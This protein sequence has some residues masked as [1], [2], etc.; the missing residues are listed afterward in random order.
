ML[1]Q[2]EGEMKEILSKARDIVLPDDMYDP[3]DIFIIIIKIQ[4]FIIIVLLLHSF[5]L[6]EGSSKKT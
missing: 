1:R 3:L 6:R 4:T 5:P 2:R